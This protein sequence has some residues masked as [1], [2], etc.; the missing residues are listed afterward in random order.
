MLLEKDIELGTN[1]NTVEKVFAM[2]T[3]DLGSIH[4]FPYGPENCQ[5]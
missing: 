2:H 5:K 1:D 4:D 3:A